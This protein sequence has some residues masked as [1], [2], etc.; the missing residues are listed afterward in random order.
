MVFFKTKILIKI[1][2]ILNLG[3]SRLQMYGEE[4]IDADTVSAG[5]FI[6]VKVNF[7]EN[8][9][10]YWINNK[11]QGSLTCTK[12]TMKEGE[13]FACVNLS[14]GTSLQF[15]NNVIPILDSTVHEDIIEEEE[16]DFEIPPSPFPS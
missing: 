13:I 12:F 15:Q 14:S 6:D 8:Q 9:V 7:S 1:K 11:Y 5:G 10:S 4:N 2:R 3:I 16:E